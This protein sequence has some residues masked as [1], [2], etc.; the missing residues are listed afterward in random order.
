[1]SADAVRVALARVAR[2][3]EQISPADIDRIADVYASGAYFRDP[4]NEVRGLPEIVRIFA[5]MFERLADPRF[6]ILE[7]VADDRGAL[8]TWNMTFRIR[9]WKPDVVQTI[10]GASHL[11]FD[12]AGKVAYHRD[13]WDTGEELY[14]KLPL[15]GPVVR[16]LRRKLR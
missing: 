15:I 14:A 6:T 13:Y 2:F 11:K 1:V 8:I 5:G 3:Y 4:F 12:A 16:L 10:H 9:K 7:S